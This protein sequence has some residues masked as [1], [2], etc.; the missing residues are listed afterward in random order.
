MSYPDR[1]DW[2]ITVLAF[3]AALEFPCLLFTLFRIW[4]VYWR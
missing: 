1:R 4:W 3:I 2:I